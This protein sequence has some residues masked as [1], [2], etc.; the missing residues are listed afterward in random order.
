MSAWLSWN[1]HSYRSSCFCS[2]RQIR[3]SDSSMSHPQKFHTT[4]FQEEESTF[5][6]ESSCDVGARNQSSD[7]TFSCSRRRSPNTDTPII[8]CPDVCSSNLLHSRTNMS[9]EPRMIL[10]HTGLESS[11]TSA[12]AIESYSSLTGL[13]YGLNTPTTDAHQRYPYYVPEKGSTPRSVPT[14]TNAASDESRALQG[15]LAS[16][17]DQ[18]R[19]DAA[20]ISQIVATPPSP[21]RCWL[22]NCSGRAFTHLSNYRRHC[23][24]KSGRQAGF[25]C[26]LC[27]K[28]FTRKAAWKI[29]TDQKRCKF[30]DYDA[31]G[32][33]FEWKRR[34]S[35]VVHP[36]TDHQNP[37]HQSLADD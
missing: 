27:G 16:D 21:I 30:I 8:D 17:P 24:E 9:G 18:S 31:N 25:P 11:I 33:P 13:D 28:H 12:S 37:D 2:Q 7:R 36:V 5:T 4:S 6:P 29:H 23:R 34:S 32:V 19:S 10:G 3:S 20:T 22:H 15:S 1:V 35:V 26:S 14:N